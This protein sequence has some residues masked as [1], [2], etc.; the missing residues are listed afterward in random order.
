MI[1]VV[2][3]QPQSDEEKAYLKFKTDDAA[4]LENIRWFKLTNMNEIITVIPK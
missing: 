1:P 3:Q 2:E 4:I